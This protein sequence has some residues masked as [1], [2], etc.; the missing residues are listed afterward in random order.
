MRS[1]LKALQPSPPEV[2]LVFLK[3]WATEG[4]DRTSLHVDWEGDKVVTSIASRCPNT[5]VV[6]HSGGANVMPWADHPNVT[7]ILA[8]HLPGQ[9]AGS[10]IVD[11]L[12]GD[13]NPSGHLPY[14]VAR[15]E[16]DYDFAPI[17]NSTELAQTSDPEAWQADFKEGL[18][19]DYS[20]IIQKS[21]YFHLARLT[22]SKGNFDYYNKSVQYEFGFG[23]S[24]TT[25]TV[26]SDIE[27]DPVAGSN[28]TATAAIEPT[29]PGGN[30]R[31]WDVLYR[32][33]AKV[34]NAGAVRGAAVPQLYLSLPEAPTQGLN[35]QSVLRGFEKILLEPGQ[36]REVVFDLS[37]RDLSFWAVVSQQWVIASGSVTAKVGFSSRDVRA[38]AEFSPLA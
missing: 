19:I 16:A 31:L 5:V 34:T 25:F 3:S 24:Y 12:W 35:P 14:T 26:R 2:C 21:S 18:L 23:L 1:S 11:V 4:E 38:I 13:V 6:I 15:E 30:P 9:E 8:A 36:T 37:R 20:K 32:I 17:T 27:I 28:I 22:R 29:Q 10:S 33:R 7:A